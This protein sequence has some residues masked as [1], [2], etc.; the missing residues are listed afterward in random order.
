MYVAK[1]LKVVMNPRKTML[2]GRGETQDILNDITN[3]RETE[4]GHTSPALAGH[5]LT[6]A[7]SHFSWQ[8]EEVRKWR[9]RL[10]SPTTKRSVGESR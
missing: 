2:Q 10:A 9:H 4:M 8:V 3:D 6:V 7:H 5:S 1:A